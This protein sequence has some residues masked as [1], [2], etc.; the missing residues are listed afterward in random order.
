[1]GNRSR[2]RAEVEKQHTEGEG[3]TQLGEG[4]TGE[5]PSNTERRMWGRNKH[6]CEWGFEK[7][8]WRRPTW[9]KLSKQNETD[10]KHMHF[11]S[12][13]SNRNETEQH[14]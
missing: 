4:T 13:Y 6:R 8:T 5:R 14:R 3:G 1:M 11:L 2:W 10:E 7:H 12:A 9:E